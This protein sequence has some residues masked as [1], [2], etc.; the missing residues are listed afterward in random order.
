MKKKIAGLGLPV[1]FLFPWLGFLLS[2]FNLRSR[3]SGY[4]Y[5]AFAMLFG[6]SISFSETS[7]DSYRYAEAFIIFDNSLNYDII[8]TMYKN[9]EIRDMYRLFLFYLTSLFSSNPKVLYAFVGLIYGTISY[10]SFKILLK[11]IKYNWNKYS[12][13]LA[14]LFYTYIS[15]SNINGFRFWTG[16]VLFFYATYNFIVN[17]R[18]IYI[19]GVLATPL[20]HY[21]FLLMA[22]IVVLFKFFHKY[23]YGDK[24]VKSLL[25]YTF[26]I[27]FLGSYF[28][29]TNII[30]LSFLFDTF[31]LSGEA[32]KRIEFVNSDEVATLVNNRVGNS[33]FLSIEQYFVHAIK[34]YVFIVILFIY[35]QSRKYHFL[36]QDIS[37]LISF[38]LFYFSISFIASSFPSGERFLNLGY[39]FLFVAMSKLYFINPTTKFKKLIFLGLPI[40]SFHIAFTNFAIPILILSPVFW[41]GN[42]FWIIIDGLDFIFLK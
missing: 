25:Y 17:K 15:L 29:T 36:N 10:L 27:I 7:A 14:L 8:F 32:T 34:I 9:G 22:P 42:L 24:G 21:G 35:K 2:L 1:F 19:I 31:Q 30:N 13:V 6:Y 11:E 39:L 12:L 20:F 16:G 3:L 37:S 38:I 4:I 28:L 18:S 33:L 41:Y 5:V 40:Y 23:L 26:I